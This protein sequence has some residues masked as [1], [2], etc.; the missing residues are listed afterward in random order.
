MNTF[1]HAIGDLWARVKM[2][3]ADRRRFLIGPLL[4]TI[5]VF[6]LIVLVFTNP[7]Q[8]DIITTHTLAAMMVKTGIGTKVN[9]PPPVGPRIVTAAEAVELTERDINNLFPFLLLAACLAIGT[10]AYVAVEM[11][12]ASRARK[13]EIDLRIWGDRTVKPEQPPPLAT[14]PAT[15]DLPITTVVAPKAAPPQK[16]IPALEAVPAPADNG[17]NKPA[18]AVE[19]EVLSLGI[20]TK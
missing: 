5:L 7:L 19:P 3:I 1:M 8:R 6:E 13:K 12:K 4:A 10:G 2:Q 20:F 18:A 17:I 14:R 15:P 16:A 9:V 11:T